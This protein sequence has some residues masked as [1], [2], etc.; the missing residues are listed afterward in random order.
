MV[1]A[2]FLLGPMG[3]LFGLGQTVRNLSPFTHLRWCRSQPMRWV[4]V[5]GVC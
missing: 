1:V 3:E 2:A 4:P 5:V